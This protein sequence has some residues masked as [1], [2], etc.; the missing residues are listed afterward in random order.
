MEKTSDKERLLT[1]EEQRVIW[2]TKLLNMLH[3]VG[4]PFRDREHVTRIAYALS[5]SHQ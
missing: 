2:H 1:L 3:R 4:I 5:G